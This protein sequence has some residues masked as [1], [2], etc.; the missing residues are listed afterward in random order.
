MTNSDAGPPITPAL[1]LHAYAQG[2]FPMAD[3]A[4]DNEL[5]WYD[6]PVRGVL[7]LATFHVPQRLRRTVRRQPFEIRVDTAF[8]EVMHKCGEAAPDR[9]RTWINSRIV[10]LYTELFHMG[11]AHSVE[12]WRNGA[13]VG[14]LYGVSL[15]AAFFGESMFSR[16]VDASKVA[17]VHLAAILRHSGF[18]LLDT[19]F[20]TDHLRRFGGIEISKNDYRCRL[21]KALRGKG[22]W[23]T[24]GWSDELAALLTAGNGAGPPRAACAPHRQT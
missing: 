24:A 10:E 6:P 7:P 1:L 8:R 18:T 2:Y 20:M 12:C 3:S 23:E 16:A 13:L 19:Q 5:S 17:L 21:R 4:D 22:R 11:H 15:H 9:P 14:G